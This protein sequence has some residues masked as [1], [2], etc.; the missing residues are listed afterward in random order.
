[1]N[2]SNKTIA[3]AIVGGTYLLAATI[4]F[5]GL[6]AV[7][8]NAEIKSSAWLFVGGISLTMVFF[9]GAGI[10]FRS[11]RETNSCSSGDRGPRSFAGFD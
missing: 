8:N 5:V 9:Y 4:L 3:R 7:T 11:I 10:N 1:M 6:G 2:D